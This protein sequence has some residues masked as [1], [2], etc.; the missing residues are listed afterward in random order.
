MNKQEKKQLINS[1][2]NL[3]NGRYSDRQ[4]DCLFDLVSNADEYAGRS[5]TKRKHSR[6]WSSEGTYERDE[7]TKYTILNDD[8]GIR[9]ERRVETTDDDT[10]TSTFVD[11]LDTGR[12]I[13]DIILELGNGLLS[14]ANA[15]SE[16]DDE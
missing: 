9:I 2:I 16:K 8:E 1:R 6:G 4:V 5:N 11:I 3:S 14:I 13:I 12:E 15:F 10:N 7:V